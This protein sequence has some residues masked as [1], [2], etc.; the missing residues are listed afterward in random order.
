MKLGSFLDSLDRVASPRYIPT[1][2]M[3]HAP[4]EL[5]DPFKCLQTMSSGLGLRLWV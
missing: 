2:G 1:D 3:S 5:R 4:P